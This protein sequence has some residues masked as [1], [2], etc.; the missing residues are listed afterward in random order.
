MVIKKRSEAF[1]PGGILSKRWTLTRFSIVQV[2]SWV[3]VHGG[4]TK[5]CAKDY[6]LKEINYY[7]RKWLYGDE[8]PKI[9]NHGK[10]YIIMTMMNIHHFGWENSVI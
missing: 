10:N 2:G 8:S 5:D 3:F 6:S 4:I 1:K 9:M 7:V